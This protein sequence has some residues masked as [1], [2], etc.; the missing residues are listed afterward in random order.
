[1]K[2][3]IFFLISPASP[4]NT[5]P[6]HISEMIVGN[7]NNMVKDRH[8]LWRN[9]RN[10]KYERPFMHGVV[11]PQWQ[12]PAAEDNKGFIHIASPV[13]RPEQVRR[14][15][16]DD[17]PPVTYSPSSFDMPMRKDVIQVDIPNAV[18]RTVEENTDPR[19][20]PKGPVARVSGTLFH[21]TGS[22]DARVVHGLSPSFLEKK[23]KSR[24][25]HSCNGKSNCRDQHNEVNQIKNSALLRAQSADKRVTDTMYSVV[26]DPAGSNMI[27][28]VD[29][30]NRYEKPDLQIHQNN[31]ALATSLRRA[32]N[33]PAGVRAAHTY[34]KL[35]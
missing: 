24:R 25:H 19:F 32:R 8:P 27:L 10:N 1:M 28:G 12:V 3:G 29:L 9:F 16:A 33:T 34:S 20:P 6:T 35:H 30:V 11:G 26:N 21:G 17:L 2:G 15:L 5:T 4:V 14:I 31:A 23:V 7:P 22:T 13:P 18:T